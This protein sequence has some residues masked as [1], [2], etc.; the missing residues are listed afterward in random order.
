MTGLVGGAIVPTAPL[1]LATASPDQPEANRDE[2]RRLRE[3]AREA[4]TGLKEADVHV[5]VAAGPRGIHDRAHATLAPL[6]VSGATADLPVAEDVVEHLSRLTQYPVF[7]GDTLGLGLSVLALQ[8]HEVCG[9]VPVVPVQVP[10]ATRFDVLAS[11]GAS[12]GEAATEAGVTA[13]VIAAGDL[14]AGLGEGSPRY[15][16]DGA[17][18]WDAALIDA[19]HGDDSGAL[20]RLGPEE[21][22]R[23]KSVG[24]APIAAAHGACASARLRLEVLGYAPA[25]GVGHLVARCVPRGD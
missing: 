24:W 10:A 11:I 9:E 22:E 21:A 14:S 5:L 13:S 16:I 2:V 18:D 23:V 12:V 8:L 7:R 15:A 1:V 17:S 4:I 20:T 25:R 3:L 19:V 6:G